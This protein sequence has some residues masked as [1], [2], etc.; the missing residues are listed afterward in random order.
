MPI[1]DKNYALKILMAGVNVKNKKKFIEGLEDLI[2]PGEGGGVSMEEVETK[3]EEVVGAAPAALEA[4]Q[5]IG[6]ELNDDTT[7]STVI[8]N[9]LTQKVSQEEMEQY[10]TTVYEDAPV[11]SSD[12]LANI[13]I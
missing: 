13:C 8:I 12:E 7:A 5:K 10:F 11:I 2:S 6:E 1:S 4:L 3:I 9:Q